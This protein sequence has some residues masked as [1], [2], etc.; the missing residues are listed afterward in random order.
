[1][2]VDSKVWVVSRGDVREGIFY[3]CNGCE[4][5]GT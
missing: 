4:V 2:V 3:V 1:M 5:R